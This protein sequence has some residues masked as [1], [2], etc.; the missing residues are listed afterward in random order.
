MGDRKS[1]YAAPRTL[2]LVGLIGMGLS[3]PLWS[4]FWS[5]FL[6]QGAMAAEIVRWVD[7]DGVVQFTDPQFATTDATVVKVHPANAMVVPSATPQ[8]SKGRPVFTKISRAAKQNKRGWRGY[9]SQ[10]NRRRRR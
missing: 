6:I 1:G 7:A 3:Y 9:R 10:H 5:L 4:L 8:P 2:R